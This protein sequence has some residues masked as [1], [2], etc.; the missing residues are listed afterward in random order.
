MSQESQSLEL[1]DGFLLFYGETGTEGSHWAFQDRRFI[2]ANKSI[3]I[4]GKCYRYWDKEKNPEGPPDIGSAPIIVTNVIPLDKVDQIL[5]GELAETCPPEE[6]DF[7]L[8]FP[9]LY[10]YDGLHILK[11]GDWL[12][13]HSEDGPQATIWSGI[14]KLRNFPSFT[15]I[16]FDMWIHAEQEGVERE[17]W[18]KWFIEEYPA[19][20]I[21]YKEINAS[22]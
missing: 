12:T 6:H 19:T 16:V 11:D 10:S 21:P 4:C 20:L 3:F 8:M 15:N 2:K 17:V 22:N 14:I 9:W 13:I 1:L 18:A 7:Q 5:K